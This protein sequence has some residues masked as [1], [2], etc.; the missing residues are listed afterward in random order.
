M[1]FKLGFIFDKLIFLFSLLIIIFFFYKSINVFSHIYDGGHHGSIFLNGLEILNGKVPYKEIFLQY[2]YLNA[3]INSITI[4]F[5]NYDIIAIYF[6][7]ALFYFLSI[8]F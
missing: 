4:Y 7:T 2:G 5:F 1:N 6:N 3:L 8:F